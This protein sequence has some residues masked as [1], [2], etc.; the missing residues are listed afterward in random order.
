MTASELRAQRSIST[1]GGTDATPVSGD[2]LQLT[3]RDSGASVILGQRE[4]AIAQLFDGER[5]FEEVLASARES[6]APRLS[7]EQLSAFE[8]RLTRCGILR[9]SDRP[10]PYVDPYTRTAASPLRRILVFPL[11]RVSGEALRRWISERLPW[12]CSAGCWHVGLLFVCG[13]VAAAA[14][15]ARVPLGV[16]PF[17]IAEFLTLWFVLVALQAFVH[18]LAHAL[19]C[20]FYQVPVVEVGIGVSALLPTGWTLPEQRAYAALPLRNKVVILLAGPL[21]SV[22]W[23]ALGW[24]LWF[25]T[26]AQSA[27][28]ATGA[29]MTW[30]LLGSIPTL[31]PWFQGDA[32]ALVCEI[33]G[34]SSLRKRSFGYVAASLLN[35]EASV[36]HKQLFICY[37]A[38]CVVGW[39]ATAGGVL[40]FGLLVLS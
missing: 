25:C 31:L 10:P 23:A 27:L 11:L 29:A 24:W 18:E 4:A 5:S 26:P 21:C 37:V 17:S 7:V 38:F 14:F 13:T 30:S 19:A 1:S 33:V 34:V 15:T 3:R 39:A 20:Q 40:Y 2:R 32:Y 36:T 28:A 22:A 12:L 16:A 35:R 9:P 8:Q 6:L